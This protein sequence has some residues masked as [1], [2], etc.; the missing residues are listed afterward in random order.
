ME[1]KAKYYDGKTSARH[2]VN[3][4]IDD[5]GHL[6]ING[7]GNT[8]DGEILYQ[9]YPLGDIHFPAHVGNMR[10][11][12][13]LPGGARCE[14]DDYVA[15]A[16]LIKP[17]RKTTLQH[18]IHRWENKLRYAL[19]AAVL[20][21]AALWAAV[22]YALPVMAGIVARQIPLSLETKLGEQSL[23]LFDKTMFEPSALPE[24]RLRALQDEFKAFIGEKDIHVIFRK[25]EQ[26]GANAFALPSG[27]I[28]FT[29]AIVELAQDDRELLGVLAH[30]IGHVKKRHVMRHILQ[31]SATVVLLVM[32]T[33]DV[34]SASSLAASI[35][36]ILV[37]AKHSRAFEE[38]ADRFAAQDMLQHHISPAYLATILE[39]LTK[40]HEG[41]AMPD[42]LSTHPNSQNRIDELNRYAR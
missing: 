34:S 7:N 25:S 17:Y 19:L 31:D 15:F 26:I 32:L 40:A 41:M 29:D 28:V 20:A 39:R 4:T 27:T 37:Q 1:I 23:A 12:L 42:F 11:T 18:H 33:G 10:Y 21:V 22:E 2:D 36:T 6:S 24:E 9:Q 14:I 30:E 35:P 13:P 16:A 8:A 5:T 38:E 3:I